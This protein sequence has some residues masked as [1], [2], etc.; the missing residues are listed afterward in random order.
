MMYEDI[1][2]A[3][4][5]AE[6]FVP[7]RLPANHGCKSFSLWTEDETPWYKANS[8]AGTGAIKVITPVNIEMVHSPS[9]DGTILCYAKGTTATNLVGFITKQ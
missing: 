1:N 3:I 4:T 7:V 6:T 2:T 5:T 8:A 9:S